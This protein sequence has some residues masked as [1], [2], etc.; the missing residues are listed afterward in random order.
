MKILKRVI[1]KK[2][3]S[4][5]SERGDD[6]IIIEMDKMTHDWMLKEK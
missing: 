6:S 1:K 2:R 3:N 5:K 4:N